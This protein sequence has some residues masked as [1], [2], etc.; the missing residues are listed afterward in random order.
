[1]YCSYKYE[2][3][4]SEVLTFDGVK[5]NHVDWLSVLDD[6]VYLLGNVCLGLRLRLRVHEV[7]GQLRFDS[8]LLRIVCLRYSWAPI[9]T[10]LRE[11][12]FTCLRHPY[13]TAQLCALGGEH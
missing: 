9:S 6:L 8:V 5:L 10:E 11:T 7:K 1:M 4:R 13:P 12:F 2:I 3:R